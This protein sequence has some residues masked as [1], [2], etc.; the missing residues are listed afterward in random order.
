MYVN[1]GKMSSGIEAGGWERSPLF[2][3]HVSLNSFYSLANRVRDEK[4]TREL[5]LNPLSCGARITARI[6]REMCAFTYRK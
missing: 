1:K 4:Q 2:S 3:K 6:Q 5:C